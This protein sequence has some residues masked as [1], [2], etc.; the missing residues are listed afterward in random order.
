MREITR[1]R[2][3]GLSAVVVL[4]FGTVLLMTGN[5][6]SEKPPAE[7]PPHCDV[8]DAGTS[9][10]P[11]VSVGLRLSEERLAPGEPIG[12]TLELKNESEQPF[13]VS[14]GGLPY[15]F[16]IEDASGEIVWV[17][18]E[19]ELGTNTAFPDSLS[20]E[21]VA[22]GATRVSSEAWSGE[23]GCPEARGAPESGTYE[24]HAVWRNVE[25]DSGQL[26]L[27]SASAVRFQ[28]V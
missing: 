26:V 15:D 3:F 2:W 27:Y 7:R 23:V 16:W 20:Y 11:G 22:P 24:M 5:S 1:W 10:P 8:P 28:V 14:Q 25:R 6:D 21:F 4:L 9:P 12:L 19:A 13:P 17:W 18:S